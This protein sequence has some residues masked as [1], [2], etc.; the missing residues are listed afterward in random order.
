[1]ASFVDGLVEALGIRERIALVLHDFGG[2]YGSGSERLR[3][4]E[5]LTERVS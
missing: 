5:L 3:N 1:M 2:P 4:V